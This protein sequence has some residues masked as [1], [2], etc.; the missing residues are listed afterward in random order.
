MDNPM[1][2]LPLDRPL[3][4]RLTGKFAAPSPEWMHQDAVLIDY[5]LIVMTEGTLYLDYNG[6]HYTVPSGQYLLLPPCVGEDNL[7]HGA[8][9]AYCEFYWLHF[10]TAENSFYK[11]NPPRF[12]KQRSARTRS[13]RSACRFRGRCP[14]RT[15]WSC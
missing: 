11:K 1:I 7:R 2:Y 3:C 14:R 13:R 9:P 4:Y 6:A 15:S 10:S 8:Q 12:W 5:E